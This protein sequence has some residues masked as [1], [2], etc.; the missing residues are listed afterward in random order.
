MLFPRRFHTLRDLTDVDELADLLTEHTWTLCT[1]FRLRIGEQT[2]L[3]LNDSTSAGSAQEYAVVLPDGQQIVS[4]TFGW[5]DRTKAVA[6]IRLMLA[7][8][9]G[10][11][12]YHDLH[13]DQNPHHVC[14][15]CR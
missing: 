11:W 10:P 15:L 7:G 9:V 4:I 5:C 8:D 6:L 14:H 2:L 3:F 13:I 12:G 1:G